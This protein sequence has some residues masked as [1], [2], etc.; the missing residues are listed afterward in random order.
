[1]RDALIAADRAP[2]IVTS[3]LPFHPLCGNSTASTEAEHP[4]ICAENIW[5]HLE[6]RMRCFRPFR[7]TLS[8]VEPVVVVTN[9]AER[10]FLLL[11]MPISGPA[12]APVGADSSGRTRRTDLTV[13]A[14]ALRASCTQ[15]AWLHRRRATRT[16]ACAASAAHVAAASPRPRA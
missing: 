16:G 11:G 12:A 10:R 2:A 8:L 9:E 7:P 15:C 1:M 14:P 5:V 4:D 13:R 6:T 3:T